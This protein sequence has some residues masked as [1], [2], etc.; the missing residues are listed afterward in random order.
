V[1]GDYD[2]VAFDRVSGAIR[3]RFVPHDG[4]G[5]GIYLGAARNGL[6]FAGSPAGRLYAIDQ[7][8]GQERWSAHIAD[9]VTTTVFEPV[10]D[11]RVV[12]AGYTTFVAPNTGGV[13][14]VDARTGRLQWLKAFPRSGDPLLA[15]NWAGGPVIS[16]DVIAATSGDGVIHAY[17]RAS[18][19]DRWTIP[20]VD[21][22]G[23][24]TATH[25]FRPLVISKQTLV[26]GSLTGQVVAYDTQHQ[27]ERWRYSNPFDGAVLFNITSDDETVYVPYI[28][29]RLV[30]IALADGT[31]R[32]RIGNDFK[33]LPG[34]ARNAVFVTGS[35]TGFFGF[36]P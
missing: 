9:G 19:A 34:L 5:A 29:G 36:Q 23:V 11:G 32:W 28:T 8:T 7:R 31:P 15:A 17:S 1:A 12:A 35:T 26:A 10:T 20:A 13:V 18:G 24:G 6:V 33:W 21:A 14:V 2:I 30:A 25:D 3:W 27:R 22:T 16:G 4:Y